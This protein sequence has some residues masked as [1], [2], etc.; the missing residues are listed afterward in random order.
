MRRHTNAANGALPA[1]AERR[2]HPLLT[3]EGEATARTDDEAYI[4][5][6]RKSIANSRNLLLALITPKIESAAPKYFGHPVVGLLERCCSLVLSANTGTA[7]IVPQTE[8][9]LFY[10][11]I[12][13]N[14]TLDYQK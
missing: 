9:G 2:N 1:E 12:A 11:E 8:P 4:R 3:P 7:R 13:L 14:Q 5:I 6:Y 10:E